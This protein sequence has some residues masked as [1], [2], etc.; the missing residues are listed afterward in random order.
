MLYIFLIEYEDLIFLQ[1]APIYVNRRVELQQR[2]AHANKRKLNGFPNHESYL[3]CPE[4]P[5]IKLDTNF[6]VSRFRFFYRNI[7]QKSSKNP[8]KH[9]IDI[10]HWLV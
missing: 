2:T 3:I 7:H 10:Y 6:D 4:K 8:P 5:A 1:A 9:F